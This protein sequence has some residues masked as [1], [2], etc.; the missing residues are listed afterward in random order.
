[1]DII[2]AFKF[3]DKMSPGI[4]SFNTSK[5][6]SNFPYPSIIFFKGNSVN[7]GCGVSVIVDFERIFDLWTEECDENNMFENISWD[8]MEITKVYYKPSKIVLPLIYED[9]TDFI[10][11]FIKNGSVKILYEDFETKKFEDKTETKKLEMLIKKMDSVRDTFN[12]FF[13]NSDKLYKVEI[14]SSGRMLLFS[15]NL[16]IYISMCKSLYTEEQKKL[17]WYVIKVYLEV[18]LLK[19]FGKSNFRSSKGLI[20]VNIDNIDFD[21]L[22]NILTSLGKI[23]NPDRSYIFDIYKKIMKN[24]LLFQKIENIQNCFDFENKNALMDFINIVIV[25]HIVNDKNSITNEIIQIKNNL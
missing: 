23:L 22:K 17:L 12:D 6:Q 15:V 21:R 16:D 8:I 24:S 20:R 2:S 1:M 25:D 9:L 14:I 10:E 11:L 13:I 5:S 3:E 19:E 18:N 4:I 7:N